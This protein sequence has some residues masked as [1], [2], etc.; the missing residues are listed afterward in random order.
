MNN[1]NDL[2]NNALS[3]QDFVYQS[4]LLI[5]AFLYSIFSV[6]LYLQINSL[7][8]YVDQSSFTPVLRFAAI[9]NIVASVLL[10]AYNIISLIL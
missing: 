10:I 9:C 7:I 2:I 1:Y 6:I 8:R 3:G 5:F 4:V